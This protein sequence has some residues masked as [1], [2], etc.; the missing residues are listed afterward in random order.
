MIRSGQMLLCQAYIHL[1][2][3]RKWQLPMDEKPPK[4]ISEIINL[5]YDSQD[6]PYSIHKIAQFGTK[7]STGIGEWFGPTTI[8]NVLQ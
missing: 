4:E 7:F 1:L 6:S 3:G 8:S 5:V 2:L